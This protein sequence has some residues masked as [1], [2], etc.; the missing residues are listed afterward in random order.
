MSYNGDAPDGSTGPKFKFTLIGDESYFIVQLMSMLAYSLVAYFLIY[1]NQ[2]IQG[3]IRN[4][5]LVY[6]IPLTMRWIIS[7]VMWAGHYRLYYLFGIQM[8]IFKLCIY[9][10]SSTLFKMK[11]I[12]IEISSCDTL[13]IIK[14]LRGFLI[15]TRV[16]L[17]F[18][19]TDILLQL[20]LVYVLFK[21]STSDELNQ[22][23]RVV[24]IMFAIA[25]FVWFIFYIYLA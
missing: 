10:L 23:M 16:F 25:Y 2:N 7:A 12:E 4:T 19:I 22:V 18:F 14:N 9:I 20:V 3:P 1:K 21:I 13:E 6:I 15:N 8:I 11:K 24:L 17:L 5:L